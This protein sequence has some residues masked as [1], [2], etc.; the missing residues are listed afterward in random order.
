MLIDKTNES[1]NFCRIELGR[2]VALRFVGK[3]LL[4]PRQS[5]EISHL[6]RKVAAHH[7]RRLGLPTGFIR[8]GLVLDDT[9]RAAQMLQYVPVAWR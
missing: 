9:G 8:D 7:V 2:C 5:R 6:I 3:L 4:P 1:L